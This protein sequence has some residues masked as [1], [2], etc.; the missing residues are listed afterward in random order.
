VSAEN[1]TEDTERKS[2]N[3]VLGKK[4]S[5]YGRILLIILFLRLFKNVLETRK[6][7]GSY[8]IAELVS[9]FING[10]D[11]IAAVTEGLRH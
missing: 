5:K 2:V 6:I 1:V 8:L 7:R 11:L 10:R 3:I 4:E 9:I